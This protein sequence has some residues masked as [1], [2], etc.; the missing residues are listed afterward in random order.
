MIAAAVHNAERADMPNTSRPRPIAGDRSKRDN[1]RLASYRLLALAAVF[2]STAPIFA[3]DAPTAETKIQ[4]VGSEAGPANLRMAGPS[5][6]TAGQPLTITV[7]GLPAV[8]LSQTVGEQTRWIDSLRFD[9]STPSGPAQLEKELSMSV[10]PWEWRLRLTLTPAANGTYLV[11][12]DWNEPPY[13]LAL[14]RVDVGGSPPVPPVPPVPPDPPTP[15]GV[16]PYA[17][18]GAALKTA[19]QPIAAL[20]TNREDGTALGKLYQDASRLVASAPAAKAA[21][22]KPEIGTTTELRAWLVDNGKA[23]GLQ[24]RHAGLADAVDTYLGK[25]LGTAIRD[26]T[27]ADAEALAALAWAAW[28]GGR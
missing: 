14:H 10:S 2:L 27:A 20:K 13:G 4:I 26:V 17:T 9:V 16:N 24:G 1:L 28:E 7:S 19:V 6:G 12:C 18:P 5:V 22:T 23:L 3:A 15:P 25:Q 8:D 21:G 11:V